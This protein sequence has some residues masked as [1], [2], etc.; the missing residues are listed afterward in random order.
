M[1]VQISRDGNDVRATFQGMLTFHDHAAGD[2]VLSEVDRLVGGGVSD[3][4]FDLSRVNG[5]DSH[6]LGVFIRMLRRA[7]EL[8][9]R[10]VMEHP[11]SDVRR[12]F[13]VV[14]LD[15]LLEIAE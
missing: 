1:D 6:W 13:A 14:E 15:R 7:R 2:R 10:L 8:N 4:R 5:L 3:I 9:A 12:L 11:N